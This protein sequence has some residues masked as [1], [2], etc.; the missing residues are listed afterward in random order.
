VSSLPSFAYSAPTIVWFA[1]NGLDRLASYLRRLGVQRGLLVCDV[2]VESAL[3]ARVLEASDGR[4]ARAWAGVEADAPRP[5]VEAAA[6]E[7]AARG[8]DAVVAL[9]GGSALDT[10]KAAALLARHGGDVSA[11]DGA[12]RVPGPGLPVVAIP[13]TAGTGSEVTNLFVVKD[14]ERARKLVVIDRAVY[15]S[16]AILDP[17][18]TLELPPGLTAA[19]GVDA[20]THAIEG[21]VSRFRQPV[22]DAIGLECVRVLSAFLPRVVRDGADLEARGRVLLAA[23]MAG[24]LVSMTFSGVSHAVAHA[25]GLG[26]DVHHGTAN[27]IALPWS[28]RFNARD[29]G[30]AAAY[31]RCAEAFGLAPSGSD[32]ARALS[33][34]DALERFI[35]GLGLPARLSAVGVGPADLARLSE[36]A[37][38]DPSHRTNPVPVPDAVT[39]AGALATLL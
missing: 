5:S 27:A 37:F 16:V 6:A 14:V 18:L 21:L 22:C 8:A 38:G 1:P 26:W 28:V 23:S 31:A 12:H 2:R 11:W 32:E 15:P 39:L 3:G 34:A 7:V 33:L 17:R 9:G 4:I 25:L 29:P 30:A 24:Q 36:L 20:L 19:T 35:A 10:G 13:T